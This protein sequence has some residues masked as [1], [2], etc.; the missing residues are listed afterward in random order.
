MALVTASTMTFVQIGFTDS[1]RGQRQSAPGRLPVCSP[2]L[3]IAL[4]VFARI[5]SL[6][7]RVVIVRVPSH[8]NDKANR[9]YDENEYNNYF[10]AHEYSP[11]C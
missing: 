11:I 7:D 3:T 2:L 4:Y 8:P 9:Q 1:P 5:A 10:R 6:F